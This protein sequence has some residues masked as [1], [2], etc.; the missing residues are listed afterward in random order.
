MN[1]LDARMSS[2]ETSECQCLESPEVAA[3]RYLALVI[4]MDVFFET[5]IVKADGELLFLVN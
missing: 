4:V 3:Q 1:C 5:H 2:L